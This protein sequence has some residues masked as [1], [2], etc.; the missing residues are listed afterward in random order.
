VFLSKRVEV[1]GHF[2]IFHNEELHDY[3]GQLALLGECR[4]LWWVWYVVGR[5]W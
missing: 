4:M 1:S 5:G 3:S 2:S